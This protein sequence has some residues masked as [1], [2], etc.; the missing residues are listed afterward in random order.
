MTKRELFDA[1]TALNT[2]YEL[3]E[4]YEA[5]LIAMVK[6]GTGGG[7]DVSDYT[8]FNE[9]GEPEFIFC[10]LHKKW[11][12]VFNADGE[13]LFKEDA[14]SKNGYQRDCIEG[15]VS[16]KELNKQIKASEKAIIAD[17]LDGNVT[18]EEGKEAIANLGDVRSNIPP[19]EDGLGSDERPEL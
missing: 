1:I 17:V 3:P 18:P 5:T 12:P 2:K 6:P 11:E 9:D 13:P 16:F 8:V 4:E 15:V 19:R 7:K 14:K 10:N